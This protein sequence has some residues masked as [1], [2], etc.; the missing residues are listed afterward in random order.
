MWVDTLSQPVHLSLVRTTDAT[1]DPVDVAIA[2][3]WV[4]DGQDYEPETLSMLVRAARETVE[5]DTGLALSTQTWTYG[6]DRIPA[7]RQ[8]PL[9]I[10]PVQSVTSVTAYSV[11]D[12][13]SVV[14]TSVYR[15]DTSSQPARLVLKDGQSWP[16][17]VRPQDGYSIVFVAGWATLAAVPMT[18][19]LAVLM[20]VDHWFANRGVMSEPGHVPQEIVKTYSALIDAHKLRVLL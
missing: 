5:H 4:H 12:V 1:V 11:A 7:T 8:I 14:A 16:S 9:P 15:V 20:L 6:L 10:W 13:G 19:K 2:A 18:L 3:E 17:D